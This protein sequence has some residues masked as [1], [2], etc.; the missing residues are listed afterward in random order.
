MNSVHIIIFLPASCTV[1]SSLSIIQTID[2]IAHRILY[3]KIL[4]YS[5][6]RSP[7]FNHDVIMEEAY[8]KE[9]NYAN[10]LRKIL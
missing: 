2:F 8:K 7:F 5:K 9:M 10:H 4:E 6:W 1:I 3:L